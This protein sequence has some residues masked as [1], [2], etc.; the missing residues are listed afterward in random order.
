MK[1]L[2]SICLLCCLFS[3][4]CMAQQ[5]R[6]TMEARLNNLKK[7]IEHSQ[8]LLLS[9]K[10]DVK[11]KMQDVNL[12]SAQ[13]TKRQQHIDGLERE[14]KLIEKDIRGMSRQI[15]QLQ[16]QLEETKQ[17]YAKLL[18]AARRSNTFE[19]RLM[20]VLSAES[21]NQMFLR[22]RYLKQLADAQRS[23]AGDI[24][25]Q[26]NDIEQKKAELDSVKVCSK[27]F[28]LLKI[29]QQKELQAQKKQKDRLIKELQTGQDKLKKELARK[30]KEYDRLDREVERVIKEMTANEKKKNSAKKKTGGGTVAP[31]SAGGTISKNKTAAWS[32]EVDRLPVPV[33]GNHNIVSETKRGIEIE[34][35]RW[36]EARAIFDGTIKEIFTTDALGSGI[37]TLFLSDG[38]YLAVYYNLNLSKVEPKPQKGTK[39]RAGSIIGNV[40]IDP[41]S[42]NSRMLFQLYRL[43][44]NKEMAE[45]LQTPK[46]WK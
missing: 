37:N 22:L 10:N 2:L 4:P 39:V 26:I 23:M 12:L 33:V 20:F 7:E 3:L 16:K 19:E 34:C 24:T 28:L 41:E 15:V 42:R 25:L 17:E 27:E 31:S 30:Q 9:S 21:F 18:R 35:N 8:G 5:S 36:A 6:K 44:G 38:T 11:S 29:T 46:A 1:R 40:N 14:L 32:S 43:S 13:I 45:P